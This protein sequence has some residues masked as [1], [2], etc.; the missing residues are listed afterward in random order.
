MLDKVD[1]AQA[2]AVVVRS[3]DITLNPVVVGLFKQG[4]TCLFVLHLH[5][6]AECCVSASCTSM[7]A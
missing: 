2:I 7:L 1:S 6:L 5:E 3:D 4:T